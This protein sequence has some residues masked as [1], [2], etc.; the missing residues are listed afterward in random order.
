MRRLRLT[1]TTAD[2]A[3][4]ILNAGAPTIASAASILEQ[5]G[6][7][8]PQLAGF[9]AEPVIAEDR[10]TIDW[11]ATISGTAIPL[12]SLQ[13]GDRIAAEER[14]QFRLGQLRALAAATGDP[15][16]KALLEAAAQY[17]GADSV[18]VVGQEPVLPQWGSRARRGA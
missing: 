9:L 13:G 8:V 3:E 12:V 1:R 15:R 17:P 7:S 4:P 18:Y 2:T 5:V 14:L 16:Q 11:Y 10:N 6:R